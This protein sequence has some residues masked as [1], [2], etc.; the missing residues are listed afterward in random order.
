MS[1]ALI[2]ASS[3][4]QLDAITLIE[5]DHRVVEGLFTTFENLGPDGDTAERWRTVHSAIEELRLHATMEEQVFYPAVQEA[6]G[7]EGDELVEESLREHAE[8]KETL[9]EIEALDAPSTVF[10]QRVTALIEEVRHH[11]DEE[12]QEILPKLRE[13]LDSQVL[14]RLGEELESAKL[15]MLGIPATGE[16][17]SVG[18]GITRP[19]T[20]LG[21]GEPEEGLVIGDGV[22]ADTPSGQTPATSPPGRKSTSKRSSK[23]STSSGSK[24]STS[25]SATSS[26]SKRSRSKRTSSKTAT[27]KRPA[28]KSSTSKRTSAGTSSSKRTG[29]TARVVYRVTPTPTGRWAVARKGAARPSATFDRKPQAVARG[30]E[31]AKRPAL[32]QLVVHG[33]DGKI[34]QEFTYGEATR[35][36]KS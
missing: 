35:R 25:G 15:T 12:E 21:L 6:L 18:E 19:E 33:Q 31:L 34:Q 29:R 28:S 24:R 32:G 11:V 26:S 9:A 22:A 4:D 17:E 3:D 20:V 2:P 10:Q 13:A 30:R 23:K 8:V 16:P 7:E 1:A 27:S 14:I 5:N 36:T